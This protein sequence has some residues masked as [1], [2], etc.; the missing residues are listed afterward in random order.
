MKTITIK[1]DE[2]NDIFEMSVDNKVYTI[3]SYN[4]ALEGLQTLEQVG[5]MIPIEDG[6]YKFIALGL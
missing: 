5:D 6:K 2:D 3:D 4:G 1:I